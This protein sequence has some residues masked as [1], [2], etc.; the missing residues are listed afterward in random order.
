MIP[1]DTVIDKI[2]PKQIELTYHPWRGKHHSGVKGI[3]LITLARID[4]LNTFP[5]DYRIYD[6]DGDDLSK[7]D[8]FR[9]LCERCLRS[10]TLPVFLKK[11]PPLHNLSSGK[12]SKI[13]RKFLSGVAS[14]R[15]IPFRMIRIRLYVNTFSFRVFS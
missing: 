8:Y 13:F 10:K 11:L 14:I 2:H 9:D 12:P 15:K 5:V 6:K 7:N 4:G 3:G 1:G